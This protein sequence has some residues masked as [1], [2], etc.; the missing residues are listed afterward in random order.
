MNKKMLRGKISIVWKRLTK[1]YISGSKRLNPYV[2]FPFLNQVKYTICVKLG[3][4]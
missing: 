2:D 4:S 3:F 1:I